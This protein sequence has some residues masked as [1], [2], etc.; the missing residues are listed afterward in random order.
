MESLKSAIKFPIVFDVK[1]NKNMGGGGFPGLLEPGI[2][3]GVKFDV[4][5]WA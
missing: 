2:G 4:E 1:T 3:S 5:R